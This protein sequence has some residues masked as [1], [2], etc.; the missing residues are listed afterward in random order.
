MFHFD[1]LGEE[2]LPRKSSLLLGAISLAL[3]NLNQHANCITRAERFMP[4][5]H[6]LICMVSSGSKTYLRRRDA[7]R[8]SGIEQSYVLS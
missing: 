3:S 6:D 5:W 8:M 4:H 2:A 7:F 1:T